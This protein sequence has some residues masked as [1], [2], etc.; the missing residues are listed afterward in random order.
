MVKLDFF[1]KVHSKCPYCFSAHKA[2]AAFALCEGL[3]GNVAIMGL[4]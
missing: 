3:D 4:F 1:L 2:S